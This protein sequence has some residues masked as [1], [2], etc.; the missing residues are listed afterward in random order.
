MTRR[1]GQ[2]D[3][4]DKVRRECQRLYRDAWDGK[5]GWAEAEHGAAVLQNLHK[6]VAANGDDT[7]EEN[8]SDVGKN[9]LRH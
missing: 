1:L 6:M 8:W 7:G 2:L 9:A 4:S 3:T 5:I